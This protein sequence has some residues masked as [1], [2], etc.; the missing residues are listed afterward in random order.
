MTMEATLIIGS[1]GVPG[2]EIS[3][4][5]VEQGQLVRGLVRRSSDP[6][7]VE[8]RSVRACGHAHV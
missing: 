1:T 4:R 5:L 3:R 6:A 2:S 8:P 7:K